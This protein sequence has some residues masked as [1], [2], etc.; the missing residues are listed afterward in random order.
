M[1]RRTIANN[2]NK[3]TV[4]AIVPVDCD[5][6]CCHETVDGGNCALPR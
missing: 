1:P 6:L 5:L 4:V 2:G 3:R